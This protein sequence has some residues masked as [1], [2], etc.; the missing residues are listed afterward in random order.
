MKKLSVLIPTYNRKKRL[1]K[2]FPELI[3]NKSN[4]IEFIVVDNNSTDDTEVFIKNHT[5]SDKRVKY[6]KNYV[7]LGGN[8]SLYRAILE[9]EAEWVIIVPDDDFF[10]SEFFTEILEQIDKD[11]NVGLIIPARKNQGKLLFDKT[12]IISGIEALTISYLHTSAI[13][14]IVWN[15][16]FIN[17]PL[18]LLDGPIYPQVR[19]STNIALKHNIMY[20]VSKNMPEVLSWDE[21]SQF[22]TSTKRLPRPKDFGFFELI[23]LLDEIRDKNKSKEIMSFYFKCSVTKFMW[24]NSIFNDMYNEDKNKSLDFF[25]YLITHKTIK[26]SMIFWVLFIRNQ[27]NRNRNIH[28]KLFFLI[29]AVKGILKSLFNENLYKSSVF[30]FYRFSYYQNKISSIEK[31]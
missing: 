19:I 28:L 15:K 23:N 27:F 10:P 26:S 8:R 6:F 3:S 13:T 30:L 5:E 24:I 17:E 1:E 31:I 9:A 18:W 20:F 2:T 14:G 12:K 16:N 29:S 11:I 25:K 4:D 21:D 7:N 22:F